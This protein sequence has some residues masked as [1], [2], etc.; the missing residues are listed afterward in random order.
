MP[1]CLTIISSSRD[2]I[3]VPVLTSLL[4]DDFA[5]SKHL[6][7]VNLSDLSIFIGRFPLHGICSRLFLRAI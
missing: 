3:C 2:A 5:I 4:Y 1:L 6:A 7:V